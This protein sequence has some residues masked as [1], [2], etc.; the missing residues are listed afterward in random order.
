MT[1]EHVTIV[2][3]EET[4][5]PGRL[6]WVVAVHSAG[7]DTLVGCA[8]LIKMVSCKH[9]FPILLAQSEEVV[10]LFLSDRSPRTQ[11]TGLLP[12]VRALCHILDTHNRSCSS[13][14]AHIVMFLLV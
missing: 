3:E 9:S 4:V 10:Q 11:H 1:T 7:V 2:F 12:S 13:L 14:P 8:D 5:G 6:N